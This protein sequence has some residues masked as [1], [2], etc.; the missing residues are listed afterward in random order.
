MVDPKFIGKEY[1]PITYEVG[2]EKIKEFAIAITDDLP[3][4]LEKEGNPHGDIIAP[5]TFIV[6]IQG[7]G[8][9]QLLF[10]REMDLN[11]AM[12]VHGEQEFEWFDT[13]KPNDVLVTETKVA[14]IYEKDGN[15]DFVVG[16][17]TTK[18]GDQVVV[19]GRYNFVIRR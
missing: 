13:I 15:K 8:I 11:F 4:F 18:R 3:V 16:E 14:D 7:D 12:L 1:T 9:A 2:R 19:V 6:R 17:C 5:P 10:D